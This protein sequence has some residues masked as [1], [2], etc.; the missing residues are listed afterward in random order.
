MIELK[1]I[2][3]IF[4]QEGR[5][6]KALDDVSIL[7]PKGKIVGVIGESGAGKSTLIRTVNL[8]ERPTLGEVFVDGQNL[9]SMSD[10]QLAKARRDIGM[11]FQ[12]FNLLSS[13]TVFE[14]IA[15]PLELDK[16]PKDE[17]RRRVEE[18]LLLVG[19]EGKSDD[20]PSKLSGGQKQRV[21]IARTLATNPKVLLCDEATSA[22]DP[23]TTRSILA[24]LKD[25]NS[26]LNITILLITHEMNVVK[27]I[28]DEVAVI[29][30]GQLIEQG[31][32]AD[33]FSHPKEPLTKQFIASSLHMEIPADYQERLQ[34]NQKEG[35]H[36]LLWVEFTGNS[37]DAPVL[38]EVAR[39]FEIN[40]NIISARMD[41]IGGLKFGIMLVEF[42]GSVENENR[43][44]EFLKNKNIKVEVLGYV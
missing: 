33:I 3:K 18:L 14:N 28:C 31:S 35:K 32:V 15:L 11:I 7:V 24:L 29:S 13:R 39:R 19:L 42:I 40:S 4:R 30:G 2:T 23:A 41:Y 1:H 44:I 37:V 10:S 12:H 6:T 5:E 17:I 8:L 38:S 20:Y 27:E 26:Q 9:I 36:A 43:A 22:L 21:A 16:T 34:E 25:I